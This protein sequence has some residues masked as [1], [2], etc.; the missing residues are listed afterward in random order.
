M[1]NIYLSIGSLPFSDKLETRFRY[2][3]LNTNEATIQNGTLQLWQNLYQDIHLK[4]TESE[5]EIVQVLTDK[6]VF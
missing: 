4:V 5:N 2:N 6:S 3:N 1:T